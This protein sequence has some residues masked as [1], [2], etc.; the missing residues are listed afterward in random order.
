MDRRRYGREPVSRLWGLPYMTSAV[1]RG[2]GSTKS[3]RKEQNLLICYGDK[4]SETFA[5][6]IYGSPLSRPSMKE[7]QT[8]SSAQENDSFQHSLDDDGSMQ[9]ELGGAR[10]LSQRSH[11]SYGIIMR[12]RLPLFTAH[13]PTVSFL[14]LPKSIGLPTTPALLTI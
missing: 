12:P 9:D 14:G 6:V 2:R 10:L 7:H 8:T 1:G 11:H 13:F 3:R 5:D 4:K